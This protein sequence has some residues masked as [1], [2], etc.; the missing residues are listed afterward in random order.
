MKF[1]RKEHEDV[2]GPVMVYQLFDSADVALD[3]QISAS[4]GGVAVTGTF[5]FDAWNRNFSEWTV[6][7]YLKKAR[8]QANHLREGGL[9]LLTEEELQ[10]VEDIVTDEAGSK[11]G[12]AWIRNKIAVACPEFVKEPR[13]DS[14][15]GTKYEVM[16]W[17]HQV[18]HYAV[19]AYRTY[20]D[21]G[22]EQQRRADD[23]EDERDALK[24]VL[25]ELLGKIEA[26]TVDTELLD[27]CALQ[28]ADPVQLDVVGNIILRRTNSLLK[29]DNQMLREA[30]VT[31]RSQKAD[32]RCIEDDDRLYEAL[33]DGIKCDR[34][35]GDKAA[36]LENCR[37]FIDIRCEGGGW[38]SYAEL[39]AENEFLEGT[40]GATING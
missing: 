36:M 17:M 11:N 18:C 8:A 7:G 15:R 13:T 40:V 6:F 39:E 12:W 25:T 22:I 24:T 35:V 32:D 20:L 5:A 19:A 21:I 23:V 26:G 31:H 10:P 16:G 27:R 30:I 14:L 37:R 34:R 4:K 9:T 2:D 1:I 38:R 29:R 28:V 33:G 3:S